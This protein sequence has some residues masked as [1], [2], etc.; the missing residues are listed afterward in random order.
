MKLLY[1]ILIS[2]IVSCQSSKKQTEDPTQE[3]KNLLEQSRKA[4][5]QG[6]PHLLVSNFTD[7]IISV[8]AGKVSVST[9]AQVKQGMSDY[10]TNTHFIKWDDEAEPIIRFSADKSM[11]YAI[12]RKLVINKEKQAAASVPPDTTRYAWISVYRKVDDQWKMETIVST[13]Q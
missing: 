12:V 4:H 5:F 7:S 2:L 6:D 1:F 8:N 11:A 3:I 13:N 9:P 10:L